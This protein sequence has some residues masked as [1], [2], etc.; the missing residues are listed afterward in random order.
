[1][2]HLR[3]SRDGFLLQASAYPLWALALRLA[4]LAL[5]RRLLRICV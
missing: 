3:H 1:M 4:N 2:K 5:P